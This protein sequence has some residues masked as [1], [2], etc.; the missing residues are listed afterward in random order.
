MSDPLEALLVKSTETPFQA[1]T[2]LLQAA[3]GLN[4]ADR[5]ALARDLDGV[6]AAAHASGYEAALH[7]AAKTDCQACHEGVEVGHDEDGYFHLW[8]GY[9]NNCHAGHLWRLLPALPLPPAG[10]GG[11]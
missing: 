1:I 6:V 4:D 5:V 8:R 9:R 10:A 11:G 2:R 7:D 3:R